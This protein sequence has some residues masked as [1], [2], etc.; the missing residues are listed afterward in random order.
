MQI[1]PLERK[2]AFRALVIWLESF[3]MLAFAMLRAFQVF[4]ID[5][6]ILFFLTRAAMHNVVLGERV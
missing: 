5:L 2:A 1:S 6:A 4:G 3:Y